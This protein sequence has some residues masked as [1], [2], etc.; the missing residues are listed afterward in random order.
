MFHKLL[1]AAAVTAALVGCGSD[2]NSSSTTDKAAP[3]P[4]PTIT[5][6]FKDTGDKEAEYLIQNT[7]L[8]NGELSAQGAG[9]EQLGWNFYYPVGDTLFVSGYQ[10]KETISYKSDAQGKINKLATFLFD[11]PL[12]VFGQADNNTLLATNLPRS[13]AHV[14]NTLYT[15]SAETG[16]ITAKT[17]YTIHD[18]DTGVRGDGTVAAPSAIQVRGDKL[19]IAFHKLDDSSPA[20]LFETN[21]P[22]SALV[23][24]YDYPLTEN[25]TP[26]KIISDTRTSH[27]GVNG[28]PTNMIQLDNGDI[29]SLSNGGIAAGFSQDS[30][31]P[32]GIL[33]IKNGQTE[34]DSSYFLNI[35]EKTN[36]G[37]IFWFSNIGG[38]KALARILT[39]N[40]EADKTP[41]SAFA[42][43]HFTMKLVLID[44]E[45][46]TITDVPGVPL[47][48]KRWTSPLEVIDGTVY[49]SIETKDDAHIYQYDIAT[50]TVKKGAKVIGKTLKGFYHLGN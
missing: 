14:A 15:V 42:K 40:T 12:E 17:P 4:V 48:Q 2:S 31:K 21:E 25:A 13:G 38:N 35:K 27:I 6:S 50:N 30:T 10:N 22:D 43:A 8:M 5:T 3:K 24:V 32:S 19:F 20:S 37:K 29:Y 23:A 36:G 45:A 1:L 9:F 28:N 44:L 41:W 7:D 47:H 26:V 18:N 11:L 46:E 49:L 33:R 39:P 16:R 34:F